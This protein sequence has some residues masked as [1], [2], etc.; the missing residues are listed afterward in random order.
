MWVLASHR[1]KTV[2]ISYLGGGLIVFWFLLR[3][4]GKWSNLTNQYFPIGLKPPTRQYFP[5]WIPVA[6]HTTIIQFLIYRWFFSMCRLNFRSFF[7]IGKTC[8]S[9]HAGKKSQNFRGLPCEVGNSVSITLYDV[10]QSVAL[11]Q[12]TFFTG[13][14]MMVIGDMEAIFEM[15]F[16]T[17]W[18]WLK[19]FCAFLLWSIHS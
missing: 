15:G 14:V 8:C 12:V 2:K 5:V 6:N 18:N 17:A 11:T 19:W 16:P 4:L 13:W 1:M 7:L 9:F 10:T 3:S